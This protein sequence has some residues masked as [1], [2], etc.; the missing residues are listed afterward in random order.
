MIII[1]QDVV[2]KYKK[3]GKVVCATRDKVF[4]ALFTDKKCKNFISDILSNIIEIPKEEILKHLVIKNSELP[5]DNINE[6]GKTTDLI[7]SVHKNYINLEM[8]QEFY[9][10]FIEKNTSYIHKIRNEIIKVGDNY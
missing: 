10:G 6:K 4:K 1:Y 7:M 3:E 2:E 8:Y 9:K 5:I